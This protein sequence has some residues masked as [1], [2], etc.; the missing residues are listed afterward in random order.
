MLASAPRTHDGQTHDGDR[1]LVHN[2]LE[3][4]FEVEDLRVQTRGERAAYDLN[5]VRVDIE[6]RWDSDEARAHA[7]GIS[8][9]ADILPLGRTDLDKGRVDQVREQLLSEL[10]DLLQI[11]GGQRQLR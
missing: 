2:G 3:T 11:L 1:L 7:T 10:F 5:V 8:R 6:L 4:A 9:L